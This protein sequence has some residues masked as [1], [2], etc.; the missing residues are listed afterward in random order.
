METNIEGRFVM[1]TNV[2][3][4]ADGQTLF[5][6]GAN[7]IVTNSA[8][9]PFIVFISSQCLELV[10]QPM[11]PFAYSVLG[12]MSQFQSG[13][14]T[15]AGYELNV[16]SLADINTNP[17]PATTISVARS[18]TNAV[19]TWTAVPYSYSYSVLSATNVTGPYLPVATGL[20]FNST[21]GTYTVPMTG[22]T[23]FYEIV[24]P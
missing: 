13:A 21:S 17:P 24:S 6:N 5:P 20:T 9:V 19:L 10:G 23:K 18:G 4:G 16:T 1:M 8:G 14:Y 12:A 7:A 3:F 11:P 15:S 22:L 2:Y